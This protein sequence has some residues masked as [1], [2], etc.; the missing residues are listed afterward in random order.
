MNFEEKMDAMRMNLKLAFHDIEALRE[1]VQ[2]QRENIQAQQAGIDALASIFRDTFKEVASNMTI[3]SQ[4]IAG[5][6]EG[7]HDLMIA[8]QS[9]L[10]TAQ[11]HDSRILKLESGR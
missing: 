5:L 10:A 7:A 2:A 8:T 4:N 11:N 1:S 3:M 6:H 9:L